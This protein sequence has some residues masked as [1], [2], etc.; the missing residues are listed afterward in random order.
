[1]SCAA[2]VG[3]TMAREASYPSSPAGPCC[4]RW[5]IGGGG[6]GNQT[7][8]L[9]RLTRQGVQVYM[10]LARKPGNPLTCIAPRV[11]SCRRAT[12]RHRSQ[13]GRGKGHTRR[14]R[15]QT[16]GASDL[17]PSALLATRAAVTACASPKV[18][19]VQR[20][21][22]AVGRRAVALV[23]LAHTQRR[24][25]KQRRKLRKAAVG[26]GLEAR[27]V[28]ADTCMQGGGRTLARRSG[29]ARRAGSRASNRRH[30][31]GPL[32][33]ARQAGCIQGHA[34]THSPTPLSRL[35]SMRRSGRTSCTAGGA[36]SPAAAAPPPSPA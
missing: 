2:P 20:P 26:G 15:R 30:M 4:N 9:Q 11:C 18:H 17:P 10:P 27:R 19:A 24:A 5:V 3:S 25:A 12:G 7:S 23:E 35:T 21:Q 32:W 1:M 16:S 34:P 22:S 6:D 36:A 29:P 28:V 13:R 33:H 8:V 31:R 14:R